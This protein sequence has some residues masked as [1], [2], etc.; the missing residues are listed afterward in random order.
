MHKQFRMVV[1]GF[2]LGIGMLL[3]VGFTVV[4]QNFNGSQFSV[5][6]TTISV[7]HLS[8][9]L[10]DSGTL[11]GA[12]LPAFSGVVTT[13]AGSTVTAFGSF[14]SAT[15]AAGLSDESGTGPALFAT[16]NGGGLTA[17]N[18]LSISN[19][20]ASS[21]LGNPTGASA[22]TIPITLDSTLSFVGGQLHVIA[23]GGAAT[24]AIANVS[25]NN[26]AFANAVTNLDVWNGANI[27][28]GPLTNRAGHV[29]I[30]F[31]LNNNLTNIASI[32]GS[33]GAIAQFGGTAPGVMLGVSN[34]LVSSGA[35]LTIDTNAT[36]ITPGSIYSASI[37]AYASSTGL[38]NNTGLTPSSPWPMPYALTR[39]GGGVLNIMPGTNTGAY[40]DVT[41]TNSGLVI[42]PYGYPQTKWYSIFVCTNLAASSIFVEPNVSNV[43]VQGMNIYGNTNQ[44]AIKGVGAINLTVRDCWLH[45]I[46]GNG[47]LATETSGLLVERCAINNAGV[48]NALVNHLHGL[49]V[50]GT[51]GIIRNNVFYDNTNGWAIQ[52]YGNTSPSNNVNWQVYNNLAYTNSR[53]IYVATQ[54]GFT[55]YL[56]NN[57]VANQINQAI[58]ADSSGTGTTCITN[59]VAIRGSGAAIEG[60]GGVLL[61]DY[62]IVGLATNSP[63]THDI[64]STVPGFVNFAAGLY[65]PTPAYVGIGKAYNGAIL[66]VDFFGNGQITNSEIGFVSYF[67]NWKS[68]DKRTLYQ[69]SWP[70]YWLVRAGAGI[71]TI[72]A[73]T[74]VSIVQTINPD[75]STNYAMSTTGAPPTGTASG[76]LAG[77]YP[78]PTF[79]TY[80]SS[81]LA[82][83]ITDENGTGK[84]LFDAGDGGQ[85]THLNFNVLTGG[86]H[87]VTMDGSFLWPGDTLAPT[88]TT[89]TPSASSI[90]IQTA[91]PTIKAWSISQTASNRWLF[92][93][94][95]PEN[96]DF[97]A[98][99][100]SI[101]VT[102]GTN[103]VPANA[104]T[105]VWA[106]GLAVNG[107]AIPTM[108]AVTNKLPSVTSGIC[109]TN[110]DIAGLTVSG[111]VTPGCYII[112]QIESRA[113]NTPWSS[114]NLELLT[115]CTLR[116]TGTNAQNSS[117]TRP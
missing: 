114:T 49:Y 26:V 37:T 16:G 3:W 57:T 50:S 112:G 67:P 1:I 91:G 83:D 104:Q 29:D 44:D 35:N 68:F 78:G 20:P 11:P 59:C 36:L 77:T 45:E 72:S 97:Q 9:A 108:T 113:G 5:V 52:I 73:S 110:F 103:S 14:S 17:L 98:V 25:S 60:L 55:N 87:T 18:G 79:A 90:A 69:S 28:I 111:T 10:V 92:Q 19:W 102:S 75:G 86:V 116:Y 6:G 80:A 22:S 106:A 58:E 41:A 85:L 31:A 71:T 30:P 82:S 74:G 88:W 46:G 32:T 76:R 93:I 39:V 43:V 7:A 21:L 99:T 62:N 65:W 84:V 109:S 51:N 42:Q 95:A 4:S 13:S 100:L 53:G 56:W 47:V 115:Y 107:T 12:R 23:G 63:G 24:N 96:W 38:T 15:L 105:N 89:N 101:G 27:L 64:V 70:D 54:N 66:P 2:C 33:N 117:I 8:G 48:N 40:W 81:Q 94:A 34:Q 61:E